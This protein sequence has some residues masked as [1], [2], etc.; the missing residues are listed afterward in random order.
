[1]VRDDAVERKVI[2]HLEALGAAYQI[3]EC[4]PE[5]ADTALFCERYGYPLDISANAILVASRKPEGRHALCLAL[6]TTRL[7]VNHV[8]RDLLGV[9]RL[10]FASADLT[11]EVTGM[12]IGGV[13]PFGVPEDLAVLVDDR[14]TGLDRCIVGGGSRSM[15]IV[16]DPEVFRRMNGVSVVPRLAG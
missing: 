10:S 4:D 1:M 5:A 3:V 8:V 16:V 12:A 13:T 15:K 9:K 11:V 6:A 2:G 7:D 14:I